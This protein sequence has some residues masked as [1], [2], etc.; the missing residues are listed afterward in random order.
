M[1]IRLSAIAA[2]VP[3]LKPTHVA[4]PHASGVPR[5]WFVSGRERARRKFLHPGTGRG[6]LVQEASGFGGATGPLAEFVGDL[7]HRRMRYHARDQEDAL[8]PPNGLMRRRLAVAARRK[9]DY[10]TLELQGKRGRKDRAKP[11]WL[12]MRYGVWPWNCSFRYDPD[13]YHGEDLAFWDA[14]RDL[15]AI[16]GRATICQQGTE[17]GR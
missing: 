3:W 6:I 9:Q 5:L 17:E 8:P 11:V 4:T 2:L 15:A 7:R 16:V 12:S 10:T 14:R 13:R 1:C